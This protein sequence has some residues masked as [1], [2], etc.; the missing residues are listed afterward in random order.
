VDGPGTTQT[1][2]KTKELKNFVAVTIL[3]KIYLTSRCERKICGPEAE[4]Q[5]ILGIA[6]AIAFGHVPF[7]PLQDR[8]L[9]LQCIF[10]SRHDVQ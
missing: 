2:Q 7:Y 6:A 4:W 10:F 9:S 8:L 3:F 5:Y 1:R